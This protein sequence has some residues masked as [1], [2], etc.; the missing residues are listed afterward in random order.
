MCGSTAPRRSKIRTV[1][2]PVDRGWSLTERDEPPQRARRFPSAPR[3]FAEGLA[4]S[5]LT[6]L[7]AAIFVTQALAT[8]LVAPGS[9]A[10]DFAELTQALRAFQEKPSEETATAVRDLLPGEGRLRFD[11][12]T[13][14][15]AARKALDETL[16]VLE[17]QVE[18]VDREA[19]R[20]ALNLL[21]VTEEPISDS[22]AAMLGGL[23]TT[24]ARVFLEELLWWRTQLT[25]RTLGQLEHDGEPIGRAQRSQEL[26]RVAERGRLGTRRFDRTYHYMNRLATVHDYG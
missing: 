26:A 4:R 18:A 24:D 19:I 20:L 10:V 25:P 3:R 13:Q 21:V 14:A 15:R 22:L 5:T 23:I 6:L 16:P 11:D 9:G 7:G 12:S 8:S 2:R 1:L 17:A